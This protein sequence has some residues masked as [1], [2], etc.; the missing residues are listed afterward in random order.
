MG[1]DIKPLELVELEVHGRQW[2]DKIFNNN[3]LFRRINQIQQDIFTPIYKRLSLNQIE[4]EVII[5]KEG[6]KRRLSMRNNLNKSQYDVP[7]MNEDETQNIKNYME[8][9]NVS[10]DNIHLLESKLMEKQRD[11]MRENINAFKLNEHKLNNL[12]DNINNSIKSVKDLQSNLNQYK[13]HINK[14]AS[15]PF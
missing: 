14:M 8:I 5:N 1:F 9:C 2:L 6:K 10:I 3:L 11:I 13:K 7:L 12:L 4:Q 15:Y